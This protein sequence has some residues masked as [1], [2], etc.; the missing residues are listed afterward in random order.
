MSVLLMVRRYNSGGDFCEVHQV[1]LPS[2]YFFAKHGEMFH[3][4]RSSAANYFSLHVGNNVSKSLMMALR[5]LM[6][7]LPPKNKLTLAYVA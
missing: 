3:T 6:N 1:K 4:Q 5:L 7:L 2:S